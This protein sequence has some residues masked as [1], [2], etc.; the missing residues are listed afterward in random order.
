MSSMWSEKFAL[1][2][3]CLTLIYHEARNVRHIIS[4]KQIN[5]E[6]WGKITSLPANREEAWATIQTEREEARG[7]SSL[8]DAA[9]VF[10]KRFGK[11]LPEIH[12]MFTSPDWKHAKAYGGNAWACITLWVRRYK[13]ASESG[14]DKLVK[15]ITELLRHAMHNNGRIIDKCTDLDRTLPRDEK[16]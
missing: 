5:S 2:A 13:E 7:T 15:S 11:S 3:D 8:D 16:R 4:G 9:S 1:F 6:S 10:L 12:K 14:Q